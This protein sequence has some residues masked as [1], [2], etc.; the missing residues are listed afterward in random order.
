M[1][2]GADDDKVLTMESF[3]EASAAGWISPEQDKA[4][5]DA[6]RDVLSAS[7]DG[8]RGRGL[9]WDFLLMVAAK[10]VEMIEECRSEYRRDLADLGEALG[11]RWGDPRCT[12]KNLLNEVRELRA[13]L[14]MGGE[15]GDK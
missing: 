7:D 2:G 4:R 1:T 11:I 13:G 10:R 9:D 6:M 15:N 14:L 3:E 12:R 8:T 5:R